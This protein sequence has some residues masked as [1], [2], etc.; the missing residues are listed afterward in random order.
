MT[1]GHPPSPALARL[2]AT[3]RDI[4]LEFDAPFGSR[5][6]YRVGGRARALVVVESAAALVDVAEAA[7]EDR[8]PVLVMGRGS[9]MLVA[10]AGYDGVVVVLGSFAEHVMTPEV[11]GPCEVEVGAAVVLPVLARRLVGA[12]L[13]GLEWSVGVPGS[14]GGAVR[15]NAGGHGSD[16]AASV[17]WAEV[18]D[19]GSG[20]VRRWTPDEL[21]LGFRSSALDDSHVVSCA[22]FVL[23]EGD[24]DEGRRELEEVV[25]WRRAHQP[26]GQNC[27]SVFVNPVPGRVAA[28]ALID[29][30]GL[31]GFRI[32]SAEVSLKHA[33]F[34][35]ADSGGSADDVLAVME[36]VRSR[37]MSETG[38]DLRSEVRLIG[39]GPRPSGPSGR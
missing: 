38:H 18:V 34:I 26:G 17:S 30:L 22:G 24:V 15:M 2:G 13:R 23:H 21:G 39:F 25:A 9:N 37:V 5:T 35:Q 1:T 10:D 14:V 11:G 28:G 29:G 32:G 16:I 7:A 3:G 33:N 8:L 6:T 12:G 31:R 19:L 36:H 27:G 4:A 20:E